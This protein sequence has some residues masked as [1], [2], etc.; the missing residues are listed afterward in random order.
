MSQEQWDMLWALLD[1]ILPSYVTASAVTDKE[2]QIAIPDAEFDRL[3]D[4]ITDSFDNPPSKELIAEYLAYRPAEQASFRV[5]CL[6]SLA[7]SPAKTKL[8]KVLGSLG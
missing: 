1:G 5:D 3:V 7:A 4:N 8:A 2:T 6:R